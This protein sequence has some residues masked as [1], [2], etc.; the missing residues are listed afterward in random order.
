MIPLWLSILSNILTGAAI[1]AGGLWRLQHWLHANSE[2]MRELREKN[3]VARIDSLEASMED[4]EQRLR[5]IEKNCLGCLSQTKELFHTELSRIIEGDAK[6]RSQ[7]HD[8]LNTVSAEMAA[9]N[10]RS[11][12]TNGWLEKVDERLDG[13]TKGLA[14]LAGRIESASRY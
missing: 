5:G 1:V 14:N 12:N 6:A 7:I 2:T 13:V 8:R 4:K 11:A 10:E 9:L 3:V